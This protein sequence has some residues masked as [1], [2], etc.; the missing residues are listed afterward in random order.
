MKYDGSVTSVDHDNIDVN[1]NDDFVHVTWW[2][3]EDLTG[4]VFVSGSSTNGLTI[5]NSTTLRIFMQN[6]VYDFTVP[7]MS[8]N[9]RYMASFVRVLGILRCYLGKTESTTGGVAATESTIFN[10]IGSFSNPA[11]GWKGHI[12]QVGLRVGSGATSTDIE[13]LFNDN[14]GANFS[15]VI[16]SPTAEWRYTESGTDSTAIDT[17]GNFNGTLNNFIFTPSPWI[18]V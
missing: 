1:S 15:D 4:R 5:Q 3:T 18:A 7:E 6:T 2:D 16:T 13:N 10:K 9:T 17:T 12:Y 14:D 11:A 8:L